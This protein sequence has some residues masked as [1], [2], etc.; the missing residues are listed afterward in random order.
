VLGDVVPRLVAWREGAK[1]AAMEL[2]LAKSDEPGVS[3]P[4]TF[5]DA[6]EKDGE[7]SGDELL[8]QTLHEV[9]ERALGRLYR[10]GE[11][12]NADLLETLRLHRRP[13]PP[14]FGASVTERAESV[15]RENGFTRRARAARRRAAA[16]AGARTEGVLRGVA[17]GPLADARGVPVPG[18]RR[19]EPGEHPVGVAGPARAARRASGSST[20]RGCSGCRA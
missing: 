7:G 16:R 13:R 15:A 12:D 3:A 9:L 18:P 17:A 2:E 6:Y 14:Q 20:S 1:L 5:K 4:T 8:A 19:P 10:W 11:K